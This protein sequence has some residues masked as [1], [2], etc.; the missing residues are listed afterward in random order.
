MGDIAD[1]L[2]ES[3]DPFGWDDD[4]DE[5]RNY[6]RRSRSAPRPITCTRC[7]ATRLWWAPRGNRRGDWQ[8]MNPDGNPHASTCNAVQP[9]EFEDLTCSGA[10][11][12][13]RAAPASSR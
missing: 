3:Q 13:A 12:A 9:G 10:T 8:L 7:G 5:P 11:T 1:W 6:Y 2:L 4:D